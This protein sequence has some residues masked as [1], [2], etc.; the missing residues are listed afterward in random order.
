MPNRHFLRSDIFI[1]VMVY[2]FYFRLFPNEL[3]SKIVYTLRYHF[4][5]VR[6]AKDKMRYFDIK[7]WLWLAGILYTFLQGYTFYTR[8]EGEAAV[9][10][11]LLC[12]ICIYQFIRRLCT[13]YYLHMTMKRIDKLSGRAFERYLTI[14]FR[15]LGY[16]VKLT[17]YS[18]DYGADLVLRKW[19]KKTV[20][21][22]KRYERNVGIAAVQEVVGSIAYYKADNA[23]VVTNSNFTKSA[24]NL[25]HRNEV[26][27][28]GRKEIQKKFHIKE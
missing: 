23:M 14:Q 19:G 17:S 27:L 21:Q 11:A 18:H 10:C 2:S 26:E 12:A 9:G 16:R 13:L 3:N 28:W 20:V 4:K 7:K 6:K 15:H 22:A 25:A 24:R 8:R 1:F 5:G